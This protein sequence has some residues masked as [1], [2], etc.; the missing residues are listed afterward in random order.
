MAKTKGVVE[1]ETLVLLIVSAFIFGGIGYIIDGGKGLLW[2]A[3][4]GPIGLII[5][6]ILKGKSD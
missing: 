1:M 4:L 3:F 5:A 6:A 2:G